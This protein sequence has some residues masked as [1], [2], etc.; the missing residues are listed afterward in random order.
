MKK[1]NYQTNSAYRLMSKLFGDEKAKDL[2][3]KAN[4]LDTHNVDG[5]TFLTVANDTSIEYLKA[6][7]IVK[8]REYSQETLE[9]RYQKALE[10]LNAKF[11][12]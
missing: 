3:D 10:K 2:I 6:H 4:Y 5:F 11:N 1:V 7:T 8:K 12:K 9:K